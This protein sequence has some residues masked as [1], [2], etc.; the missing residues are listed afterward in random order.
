MKYVLRIDTS[1]KNPEVDLDES[2]YA[3]LKEARST[4]S[5]GLAMEEKYEI[6]ISNY[7]EFEKEILDH[8]VQSMIRNPTDYEDFFQVRMSFSR[9]VV[10][11]LSATRLYVDQLHRH[12]AAIMSHNQNTEAVVRRLFSTEYENRPEYRFMEALRNYV[13]HRGLP[14]HLVQV[15]SHA[16][17]SGRERLLVFSVELVSER[18]YLKEN[19]EFKRNVL[20]EIPE[21]VDLKMAIRVYVEGISRVHVAARKLVEGSLA[22]ARSIIETAIASYRK[23]FP[24]TSVGLRAICLDENKVVDSVPL[25]LDWDNVRI[26]LSKRNSELVNLRNRYVSGQIKA[27]SK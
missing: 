27:R 24:E 20:E 15:N 19:G 8:A 17:D 25:F 3:S 22:E 16:Q 23:V 12:L 5:H 7:L 21:K 6:L 13:Q 14:V 4:L 9:R 11:L 18:K 10:N 2:G 26:E 1:G